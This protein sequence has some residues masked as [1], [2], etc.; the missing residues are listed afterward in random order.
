MDPGSSVAYLS[1]EILDIIMSFVHSEDEHSVAR[2]CRCWHEV[3]AARQQRKAA[4]A[5]GTLRPATRLAARESLTRARWVTWVGVYCNSLERFKFANKV[6]GMVVSKEIVSWCCTAAAKRGCFDVLDHLSGDTYFKRHLTRITDAAMTQAGLRGDL[7]FLDR[8]NERTWIRTSSALSRVAGERNDF[9]LLRWIV[10][11]GKLACTSAMNG[12]IANGN[13]KMLERIAEHVHL[14]ACQHAGYIAARSAAA[15]VHPGIPDYALKVRFHPFGVPTVS[16]VTTAAICGQ[17]EIL[18]NLINAGVSMMDEYILKLA[19]RSRNLETVRYVAGEL[20][21]D[22]HDNFGVCRTALEVGSYEIYM[23]LRDRGWGM[24]P[25]D[26]CDVIVQAGYVHLLRKAH[27]VGMRF[28]T[29]HAQTAIRYEQRDA[30]VFLLDNG[31]PFSRQDIPS[32]SFARKAKAG[33]KRYLDAW[34]QKRE[35]QAAV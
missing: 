28:S 35:A 18:R 22:A 11:A 29:Q 15:T 4:D 33:I 32:I 3:L 9:D 27:E 19:I 34:F 31:C 7:G 23:A 6:L 2:V 1:T 21:A 12:A 26:F 10:H 14:D 8:M 20:D 17:T 24:T 5:G 25:S 30:L 13:V 16:M